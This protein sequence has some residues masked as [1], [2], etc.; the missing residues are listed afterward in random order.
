MTT[1]VTRAEINEATGIS[2]GS[3]GEKGRLASATAAFAEA[4]ATARDVTADV[5][6]R[7]PVVAATARSAVEQAN[8]TIQ[9]S[10]DDML[11]V[12]TA[13]SFGFAAGL[14]LGGA[15]RPLVVAAMVPVAM[16]GFTLFDRSSAGRRGTG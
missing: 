15:P 11:T 4:G 7:V 6:S 10:P 2:K 13:V 16:M 14:L 5:A 3:P 9:A 12:G 1:T 8:R